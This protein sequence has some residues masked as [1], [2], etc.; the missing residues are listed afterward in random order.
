VSNYQ[1]VPTI[2]NGSA[3]TA[4]DPRNSQ[5]VL[6]KPY[7]IREMPLPSSACVNVTTLGV[8]PD[9]IT[10]NTTAIQSA[11]NRYKELYFPGGVYLVSDTITVPAGSRL[12]MGKSLMPRRDPF[13]YFSSRP[14]WGS[15]NVYSSSLPALPMRLSIEPPSVCRMNLP[16][17]SNRAAI[18]RTL[19]A[20]TA[21]PF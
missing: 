6:G 11:L 18:S 20:I 12:W 2:Y 5:V 17:G 16:F 13:A 8:V 7:E 14:P 1:N 9:G 10:D 21:A 15:K 19:S 4:N 3:L